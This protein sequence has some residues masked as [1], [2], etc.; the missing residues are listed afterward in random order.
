[1]AGEVKN[2]NTNTGI[3]DK[4]AQLSIVLR[5]GQRIKGKVILKRK[6]SNPGLALYLA[7]ER[8]WLG[9]PAGGH[10]GRPQPQ[11]ADA[12]PTLCMPPSSL[13][14]RHQAGSGPALLP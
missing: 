6:S 3:P 10:P 14:L 8:P 7:P 9:K 1:M 2:R 11:P 12:A 13:S 4:E 5:A